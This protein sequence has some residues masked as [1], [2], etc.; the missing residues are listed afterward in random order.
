M[1]CRVALLGAECTGKS[2]LTALLGL[3]YAT[4]NAATV[5]EYL[6][7]WCIRER[8]TPAREEQAHIADEQTQRIAAAAKAHPLVI[9]DTTALMTAVYSLHYFYDAQALTAALSAQRHFDLT[10]L[11]SPEGIP[12]ISDGHLRESP[13]VRASTHA[14]L[15]ALLQAQDIPHQVLAGPMSERLPRAQALIQALP[16]FPHSLS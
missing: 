10:L 3:Q 2:T 4:H 13:A 14:E 1:S 6:R 11:C 8:R 5:S 12:W 9:A 7:E 15:L 16:S